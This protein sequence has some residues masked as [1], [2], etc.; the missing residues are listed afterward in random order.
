MPHHGEP[1]LVKNLPTLVHSFAY[2]IDSILGNK[3]IYYI[4][5][6]DIYLPFWGP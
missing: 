4:I 6:L 1:T 3:A 2:D 5:H